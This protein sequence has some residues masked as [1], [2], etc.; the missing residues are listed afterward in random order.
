M[1]RVN[2][3][4]IFRAVPLLSKS[5]RSHDDPGPVGFLTQE[6]NK[7]IDSSKGEISTCPD[8]IDQLILVEMLPERRQVVQLQKNK[9]L[10]PK[11]SLGGCRASP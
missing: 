4:T 8:S 11:C 6:K 1:R 9:S 7:P 5:A 10:Y 3:S 2:I